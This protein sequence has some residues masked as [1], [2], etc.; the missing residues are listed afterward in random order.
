MSRI[1]Y[2]KKELEEM[3]RQRISNA[4]QSKPKQN[5]YQKVKVGAMK[6]RV[7]YEQKK[8]KFEM[9]KKSWLYILGGKKAVIRNIERGKQ[10]EKA[11]IESIRKDARRPRKKVIYKQTMQQP[12]FGEIDFGFP[13]QDFNN[14]RRKMK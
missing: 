1:L 10:K 2:T 5:F 12:I 14:Q 9:E 6:S 13:K 8:K 4:S 7:G 11:M 3:E